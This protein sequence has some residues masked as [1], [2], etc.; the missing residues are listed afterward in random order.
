MPSAG[1]CAIAGHAIRIGATPPRP[2]RAPDRVRACGPRAGHTIH[3]ILT[4]RHR[5]EPVGEP[6][7]L[8]CVTRESH[9]CGRSRDSSTCNVRHGGCCMNRWTEG[10]RSREALAW[11]C[12]RVSPWRA[13]RIRSQKKSYQWE[14]AGVRHP[15]GDNV[16]KRASRSRSAFMMAFPIRTSMMEIWD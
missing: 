3:A 14:R 7:V 13:A 2:R 11:E 8:P 12:A 10:H 1:W 15:L 16:R 6:V 5:A 4:G 9:G